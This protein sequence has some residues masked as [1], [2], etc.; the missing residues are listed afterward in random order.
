[1]G[2]GKTSLAENF[3]FR[4]A[5][6]IRGKVIEVDVH[7]ED[8]S[9]CIKYLA[10]YGLITQEDEIADQTQD[11]LQQ[12]P[13]DSILILDNV[14]QL[15]GHEVFAGFRWRFF[16][17]V[18]SDSKQVSALMSSF[19][20]R[21]ER[22]ELT[23]LSEDECESLFCKRLHPEIV[24][25]FDQVGQS[26]GSFLT[27]SVQRSP[28]FVRQVCHVIQTLYFDREVRDISELTTQT[29]EQISEQTWGILEFLFNKAAETPNAQQII[30][31]CSLFS[32]GKIPLDQ[33]VEVV[34]MS[35]AEASPALNR[36][37]RLG[38]VSRVIGKVGALGITS[39]HDRR[40]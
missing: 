28:F 19:D 25:M 4:K 7:D 20:E 10:E 38:W 39:F 3:A 12:I 6:Q 13:P 37:V 5:S 35:A 9:A 30:L 34:G 23:E 40:G 29:R 18:I 14:G 33:L 15:S 36:I 24:Q 1:M 2:I 31:A 27:T 17:I 8:I 11:I 16:L 21:Y 22:L 26:F 32:P